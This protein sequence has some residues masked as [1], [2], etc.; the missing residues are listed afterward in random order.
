MRR[1]ILAAVAVAALSAGSMIGG[2]AEALSLPGNASLAA[3]GQTDVEQV[4]LVCKRGWHGVKKC[5]R[6][7]P[8]PH[9]FD[10]RHRH[11]RHH[12]HH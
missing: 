2:R 8:P 10:R 5:V 3:A 1:F 9:R 4:A 7:G 12:R 11:H 6:V